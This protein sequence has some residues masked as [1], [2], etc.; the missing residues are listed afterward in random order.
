MG[1]R[2]L[3][4]MLLCGSVEAASTVGDCPT[5]GH[6]RSSALWITIGFLGQA[7]FTARFLAQWMA[8][9]KRKDSVVPVIFWWLS[10]AGGLTLMTYAVHREDPVISVGQGLGVFI[11]VR[12]LM[13]VS[14]GRKQAAKI[15]RRAALQGLHRATATDSEGNPTAAANVSDRQA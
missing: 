4:Q 13:L 10:L 7:I 6:A 9:E 14:K 15:A 5:C 1:P 11:Y 8:S 2:F 3:L 12:N